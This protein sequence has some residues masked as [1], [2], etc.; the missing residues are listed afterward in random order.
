[1]IQEE[2]SKKDRPTNIFQEKKRPKEKRESQ[3]L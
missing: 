2:Y 3:E 1:M